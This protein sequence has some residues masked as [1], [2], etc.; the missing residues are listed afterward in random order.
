MGSLPLSLL[1]K[2][3]GASKL[4]VECVQTAAKGRGLV[5]TR[6]HAADATVLPSAPALAH[7]AETPFALRPGGGDGGRRDFEKTYA[8]ARG[9]LVD[10]SERRYPLLVAQIAARPPRR[11]RSSSGGLAIA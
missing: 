10:A 2:L 8:R 3:L 5:A 9:A 6:A 4:G 1:N 7:S 11:H